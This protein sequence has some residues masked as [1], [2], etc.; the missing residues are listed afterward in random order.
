MCQKQTLAC[1]LTYRPLSVS[2]EAAKYH[3]PYPTGSPAFT[4]P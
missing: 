2:F 3:H 4:L 1:Y